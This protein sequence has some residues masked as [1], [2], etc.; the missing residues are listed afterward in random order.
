MCTWYTEKNLCSFYTW[1]LICA[2]WVGCSCSWFCCVLAS[3]QWRQ[4]S[5]AFSRHLSL[6]PGIC[7]FLRV[8]PRRS[9]PRI[10]HKDKSTTKAD[11]NCKKERKP[12]RTSRQTQAGISHL[13]PTHRGGHCTAGNTKTTHN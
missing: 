13:T 11:H 4:A 12:D 5:V 10:Q 3:L 6:S 1:C 2:D 8:T 7:R 9:K